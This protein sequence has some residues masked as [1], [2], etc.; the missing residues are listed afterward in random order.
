MPVLV[1]AVGEAG[2]AG[3]EAGDAGQQ[4]S[5]CKSAERQMQISGAGDA[6]QQ[7]SRVRQAGSY[8]SEQQHKQQ[9]GEWSESRLGLSNG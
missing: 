4:G 6:G 9:A 7:S 1:V 8:T 5:R 3:Q 2:T